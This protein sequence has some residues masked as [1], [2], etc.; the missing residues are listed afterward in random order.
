MKVAVIKGTVNKPDLSYSELQ[1]LS[2]SC[3]GLV[4]G[5]LNYLPIKVCRF[6]IKKFNYL[7]FI[8]RWF[9]K[10]FVAKVVK[11]NRN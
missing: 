11:I 6:I 9:S 3:E 8:I 1:R 10:N 7:C 5:K 4:H 2:C